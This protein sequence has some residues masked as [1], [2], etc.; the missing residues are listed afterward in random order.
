[1]TRTKAVP[2]LAL[3]LGVVAIAIIALLAHRTHAS[4]HAELNLVEVKVQ[5]NKLQNAPFR[6]NAQT[7]GSPELARRLMREGK[8]R[9]GATLADLRDE[10][11]PP[12]Q[13]RSLSGPLRADYAAL[14][15]IY[16]LGITTAGYDER[17]DRQSA[18]A[19]RAA[20]TAEAMLD[21]AGRYYERRAVRSQNQAGVGSAAVILLLLVAFGVYYRRAV[22][23]RCIANDLALD[24]QRLLAASRKEAL[25]DAL[26]GL[27]NRRALVNDLEVQLPRADEK[28]QL[29]LALFDLDGFKQ[30][31][32]SFGHP[33]GDALLV[34]LAERL[35][36]ATGELGGAYRMGG[37]EFCLLVP[38]EPDGGDELVLLAA[39]ALTEA[40]EAFDIGCSY[41]L[42]RIPTEAASPQEALRL[43]DQ[44]MYAHKAEQPAAGREGRDLLLQVIAE[45]GAGLGEH[46][47]GV[48]LLAGHTA[49]RLGLP[50]HEVRRIRLAAELH[51]VGKT[52]IPETILNKPSALSDEEWEFMRRHTVI[53]ERIIRAAPSL[54]HA[55]ELVRYSH[56]RFDGTGY[57]DA[58][59]RDEIPL[60]A[61]IIAV[62]DAFDAMVSDRAYRTAMP[63]AVAVAELRGCAGTQFH[64]GVVE[65]FCD[66]VLEREPPARPRAVVLRG[67]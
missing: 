10:T 2:A 54:A 20:R 29:M 7:G 48:A 4:R 51:D 3:A 25:T 50:E 15:R 44:R 24:N 9:I 17:A 5:L 59:S 38:A 6:A 27:G 43:A 45:R 63:I 21:D 40:G 64:P 34:R 8:G 52:A 53:G 1:L 42:A 62:C 41:G 37:D 22:Q 12:A 35:K 14:D 55:A 66:L 31:N 46:L 33:A 11:S 65:A 13:L 56:E 49:E 47:S 28:R 16:A 60:G 32:D 26:T 58:L 36:A 61:S 30:Y 23:A 39:E 19:A 67:G 18:V 57:P